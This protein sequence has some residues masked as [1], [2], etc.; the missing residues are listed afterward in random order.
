MLFQSAVLVEQFAVVIRKGETTHQRGAAAVH[1]NWVPPIIQPAAADTT[2]TTATTTTPTTTGPVL[3]SLGTWC[4]VQHDLIFHFVWRVLL[5]A[6][7]AP[8]S[9][10]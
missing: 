7:L 6:S 5:F 2:A 8:T 4:V 10:Q 9:Y 1:N 3:R